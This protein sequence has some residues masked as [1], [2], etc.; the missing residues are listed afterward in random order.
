MKRLL[1]LLSAVILLFHILPFAARSEAAF[2]VSM[3]DRTWESIHHEHCRFENKQQLIDEVSGY[4]QA[5]AA[6]TGKSNW[7]DSYPEGKVQFDIVFTAGSSHVEGGYYS[8]TKMI[9][10]IY[11]N[12][13]MAE[14]N[15]WTL[16]HEMTHLIC[17]TYGSLSLR[18]GLACYIQDE[19]GENCSVFNYGVDVHACAQLYLGNDYADIIDVMGSSDLPKSAALATSEKRAAFYLCS[20]SFS[21]YLIEQFGMQLFMKLYDCRNLQKEC[22]LIIGEDVKSLVDDWIHYL[23]DY[24]VK[25]TQ[26][27]ID[28]QIAQAWELHGYKSN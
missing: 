28:R 23:G 3:E 9:P 24:P 15:F 5:I 7:Q 8:Y 26:E 12:R 19:I 1:L 20:Y 10:R 2:S 17:P 6:L 18:E 16:A 25:M 21:K 4:V 14:Y 27:E 13:A 11:V 22:K